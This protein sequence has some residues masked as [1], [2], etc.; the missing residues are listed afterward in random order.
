MDRL[1]G[2][3]PA[4]PAAMQFPVAEPAIDPANPPLLEFE[5][6]AEKSGSSSA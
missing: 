4:I 3:P 6:V 2:P 5:D 1:P